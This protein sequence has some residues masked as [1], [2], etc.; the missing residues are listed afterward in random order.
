MLAIYAK[1]HKED[2][3]ERDKQEL[4]KIATALKGGRVQ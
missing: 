2:L 4:K 3:T 1:A